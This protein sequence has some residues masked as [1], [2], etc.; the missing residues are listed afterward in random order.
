[1]Y[2]PTP[3]PPRSVLDWYRDAIGTLE[4]CVARVEQRGAPVDGGTYA[5]AVDLSKQIVALNVP[6]LDPE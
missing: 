6:P 5:K 3:P 2:P 4:N 1:M